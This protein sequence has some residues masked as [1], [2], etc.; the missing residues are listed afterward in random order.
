MARRRRES[1]KPG[2]L[3]SV[4]SDA[5]LAFW[6]GGMVLRASTVVLAPLA[7]WFEPLAL[8][9]TTAFRR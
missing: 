7:R 8:V 9:L 4:C 1:G 3:G 6:V 2:R 5:F